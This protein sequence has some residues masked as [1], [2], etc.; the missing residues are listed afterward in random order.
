LRA[1]LEDAGIETRP[2]ICGNMVRQPAI[3]QVRHRVSGQLVGA[4]RV[5]DCGIYW[6][7]HPNM[8]NDEIDYIIQAVIGFYQ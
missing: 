7:T 5:M 8:T 6:G 1:H 3:E 4:D 2:V